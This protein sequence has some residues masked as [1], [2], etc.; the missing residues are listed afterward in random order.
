MSA[1]KLPGIMCWLDHVTKPHMHNSIWQFICYLTAQHATAIKL[2]KNGTC[3]LGDLAFFNEDIVGTGNKAGTGV[4]DQRN[5]HFNTTDRYKFCTWDVVNQEH[6]PSPSAH[7]HWGKMIQIMKWWIIKK[8][9]RCKVKLTSCPFVITKNSSER[10][11]AKTHQEMNIYSSSQM[12][13][14]RSYQ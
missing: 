3:V 5:L 14:K 1:W 7:Q 4:L 10:A 8:S 11:D 9:T 2:S 12:L 6:P 13:K